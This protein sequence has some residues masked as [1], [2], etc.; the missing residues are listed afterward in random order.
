MSFANLLSTTNNRINTISINRPEKLNALNIDTL[1][2]LDQAIK[3]A[4]SDSDVR[5]IIIRGVGEKAFVAGADIKELAHLSMER[6]L[7]FQ[8]PYIK[9]FQ[10]RLKVVQNQ[11]LQQSTDMP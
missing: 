6:V 9:F 1:N 4:V 10:K 2:E 8:S 11:S 3:L 5:L 7:N